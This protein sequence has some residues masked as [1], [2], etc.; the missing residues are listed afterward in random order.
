MVCTIQTTQINTNFI[1]S[2]RQVPVYPVV[3]EEI[4]V[5][6]PRI[7][8]ERGV[9]LEDSSK[10]LLPT[11]TPLAES[12]AFAARSSTSAPPTPAVQAPAPG[13]DDPD[14]SGDDDEDDDDEEDDEENVNEE[15]QDH[16]MGLWPVTEHY[17][18]MFETGHFPNLLQDVLHALGTYVR[19]LYK[20]RLVYEPPRACYYITRIHVRVM[21][22]GDRGFRTLS[23]HE[24]LTPLSTY[25]ASVSDA[26]RRT[27]W[28]L[29]HTYQ[30]LLHNTN[31]M[32]LPLCIRGENQIG[33]VPGGANEDRLNTLAGGVAGL[34]TDMD[35]ATW[36]SLGYT[37]SWR[38]HMQGSQ[39]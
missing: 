13:G 3:V 38:M 19:P 23:A 10:E 8:V 16:Y 18:S 24:S 30:Q 32:H 4:P 25:A 22:A 28:S 31:Y 27:L 1:P 33:I 35:T 11:P 21:D 15:Q 2:S 20:T 34:N 29:I 6:F 26:S 37:W 5:D 39:P 12:L 36:T 9:I 7:R 17:T 14:D